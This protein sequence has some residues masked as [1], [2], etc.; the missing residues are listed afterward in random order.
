MPGQFSLETLKQFEEQIIRAIEFLHVS[1]KSC[2]NKNKTISFL[3][4]AK[5]PLQI[6]IDEAHPGG[7][8]KRRYQN[9][10]LLGRTL[11]KTLKYW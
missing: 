9:I 6:A 7:N 10:T 4:D 5:I 8:N 2:K 11:E 1:K 3:E